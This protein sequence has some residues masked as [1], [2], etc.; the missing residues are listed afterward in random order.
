MKKLLPYLLLFLLS[1]T[2]ELH[3]ANVQSVMESSYTVFKKAFEGFHL[4]HEINL[5]KPNA[6]VFEYI[7][8]RH[9]FGSE[10]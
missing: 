7:L 5:R 8:E 9:N 6:D 3:I 4:S 1:N 2:N 10:R